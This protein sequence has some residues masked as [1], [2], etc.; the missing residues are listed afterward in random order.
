LLWEHLPNRPTVLPNRNVLTLVSVVHLGQ[1]DLPEVLVCL[2]NLERRVLMAPRVPMVPRVHLALRVQRANPERV[3]IAVKSEI[4][5]LMVL[6]VLWDLRV[7]KVLEEVRGEEADPEAQD[8][9]VNREH[10]VILVS[11][12][13]MVRRVHKE[14]KVQREVL[15]SKASAVLLE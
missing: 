3:V 6:Q 12:V 14:T 10:A 13:S 2:A 7:M 9:K 5:V 15:D 8:L 4:T 1:M 11:L